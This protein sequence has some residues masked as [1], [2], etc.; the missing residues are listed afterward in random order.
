VRAKLPG[1]DPHGWPDL[2]AFI[3][4]LAA[5]VVLVSLGRLSIDGLVT[6]CAALGG[7][8][9]VWRHVR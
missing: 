5:G 8:F 4:V 9:G 6:A 3:G 1:K 7:L 2:F